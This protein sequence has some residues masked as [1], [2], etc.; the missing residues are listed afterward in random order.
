MKPSD[1]NAVVWSYGSTVMPPTCPAQK[2]KAGGMNFWSDTSPSPNNTAN[3][4][5]TLNGI[6]Y[7][8]CKILRNIMAS[9][10][11]AELGDLF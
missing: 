3:F 6:F 4:E 7:V 9:A 2:H 10:A 1:T 11:E 5:P 8:V